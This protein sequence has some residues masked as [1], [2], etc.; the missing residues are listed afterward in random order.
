MQNRRYYDYLK[1]TDLI[2]IFVHIVTL[3]TQNAGAYVKYNTF[4]VERHCR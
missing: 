3:Y 2:Q 4:L 1:F